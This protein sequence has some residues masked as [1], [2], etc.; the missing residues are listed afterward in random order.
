MTMSPGVRPPAGR[1]PLLWIAGA[2]FAVGLILSGIF[3]VPLV[4]AMPHEPLP[5]GDGVVHLTDDGLTISTTALG[6]TPI[7]QAKDAAGADIALMPPHKREN[8]SVDGPSYYVIAHSRSA[9]PAQTVTVTCT[10]AD[11]TIPYFVGDRAAVDTLFAAL[12]RAFGSF[13]LAALIGITLILI[14]RTQQRR[15]RYPQT[16]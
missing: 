9:V 2:C 3:L 12:I 4:G 5:L 14:N 1:Q 13:A 10:N 7:C 15:A 16:P 8:Y 11:N 6:Q